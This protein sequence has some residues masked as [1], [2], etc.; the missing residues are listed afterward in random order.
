MNRRLFLAMAS[1]APWTGSLAN[2]Q[3]TKISKKIPSSDEPIPVIGMGTWITFNVGASQKLRAARTQVLKTFFELGGGMVDSS[4]M[5]GS[6]Q[7]V[8]GEALQTLDYPSKLFSADKIW[9]RSTDEGVSQFDD[10]L[11]LWGLDSLDLVQVH[12]LV[13]WEAHLE[14]LNALKEQGKIKYVGITTS[15]GSRHG[16]FEEI[17]KSEQLDFIQLTY[18]ITRR[19]VEQR[20]LP[21][22]QEKGVAVIANRPLDG[23]DLFSQFKNKPLPN[24]ASEYDIT[25]WAQF[26]LKFVVSHPAV[27]CAIPATS[28]VTHM[29]ENMGACYGRLPDQAGRDAMLKYI[30]SV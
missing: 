20:L 17:L 16:E 3:L 25:N 10:M 24:W 8:I 1:L 12:N 22:A 21:L 27:T 6:A 30:E 13:N 29:K 28:K 18:N 11:R 23:G 14:F 15:H 26:F 2:T 9:T 4:P 19:S 5:Y 7:E